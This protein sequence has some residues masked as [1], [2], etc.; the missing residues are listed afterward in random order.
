LISAGPDAADGERLQRF[1]GRIF[2]AAG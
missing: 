2:V 1:V